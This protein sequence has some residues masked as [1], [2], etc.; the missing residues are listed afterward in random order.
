MTAALPGFRGRIHASMQ[1]PGSSVPADLSGLA[2]VLPEIPRTHVR[3][4]RPVTV[5]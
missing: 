3:R 1:V 2:F 4:K 5:T